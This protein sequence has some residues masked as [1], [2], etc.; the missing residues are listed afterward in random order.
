[1]VYSTCIP[2]N[3]KKYYKNAQI[4]FLAASWAKEIVEANPFVDRIIY[5]DAPWFKRGNQKIFEFISFF[6]LARRLRQEKF[7]LGIDLRGDFRH[8]LL[9]SLAGLRYRVGFGI[10]GGGFLLHKKVDYRK[11]IHCLEHNLDT[12]RSLNIPIV[13]DR[14]ILY[15]SE[16][17]NRLTAH[18]LKENNISQDD[19]VIVFH[20]RAGSSAKNWLD[21]RF[22]ELIKILKQ[23]GAKIILVGSDK[24]KAAADIIIGMSG[25]PALNLCGE[26][27]LLSLAAILKRASLFVGLD[28][29]PSHIAAL[30]GTPTVTLYSGTNR[31]EEWAPQ[32]KN[33]TVIQKDV[34]CKD[35]EKETCDDN[36]CMQLISVSDVLSAIGVRRFL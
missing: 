11:G 7:D 28:S 10:T 19:F 24:D 8:I 4:T 25:A 17:E 36:L 30:A 22:A 27:S 20:T 9:M 1:M 33:V 5:W 18:I 14:P 35:C 34:S 29:A 32:G 6:S 16:S 13:I 12:L 2:E 31:I 15:I 23:Q 21:T 3:L 26:T